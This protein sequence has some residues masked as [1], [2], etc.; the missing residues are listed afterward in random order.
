MDATTKTVSPDISPSYKETAKS[1]QDTISL[2]STFS[3][4]F[5]TASKFRFVVLLMILFLIT[6]QVLA[7]IDTG[8]IPRSDDDDELSSSNILDFENLPNFGDDAAGC[9]QAKCPFILSEAEEEHG[10]NTNKS[11]DD[12]FDST[13]TNAT[14]PHD[15]RDTELGVVEEQDVENQEYW[16]SHT[17]KIIISLILVMN[18]MYQR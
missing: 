1:E 11:S 5:C 13:N 2:L 7:S 14:N 17:A 16:V 15:D 3:A 6:F 12:N 10:P 18:E 8:F 9:T 4:S